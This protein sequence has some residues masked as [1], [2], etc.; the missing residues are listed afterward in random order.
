MTHGIRKA[1]A[2]DLPEILEIIRQGQSF[3]KSQ[4]LSQWQEDRGPKS[5]DIEQDIAKDEGYVFLYEERPCGY[6]SLVSGVDPVYTAITEGQW[7]TNIGQVYVSVHRV[8]VS[9]AI[10]GKG[11]GKIFLALIVAEA[12]KLGYADIRIDTHLENLIMQKVITDTGFIYRGMV[13]FPFFDG[14]RKA[15]QMIDRSVMGM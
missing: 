13:E 2:E 12:K 1:T 6:T 5:V 10:R 11:F 14:R 9:M 7:E 15:Y 4:G 8:A 3:L